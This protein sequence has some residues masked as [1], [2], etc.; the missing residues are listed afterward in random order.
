MRCIVQGLF[1]KLDADGDGR[2]SME[3]WRV[4]FERV[5]VECGAEQAGFFLEYLERGAGAAV[6]AK[7]A[8]IWPFAV[9]S[10]KWPVQFPGYR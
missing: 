4:L 10:G 3:E 1:A 9:Q 5:E 6:E 7:P 8:V 2:V